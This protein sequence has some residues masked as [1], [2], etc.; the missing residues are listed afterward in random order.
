MTG[1]RE[2]ERR[3]S[4]LLG[5]GLALVVHGLALLALGWTVAP[6][7]WDPPSPP[8]PVVELRLLHQRP[9]AQSVRQPPPA[10][11]KAA[12][13]A[14]ASVGSPTPSA[15]AIPAPAPAAPPHAAGASARGSPV[16]QGG[17]GDLSGLLRAALGCANRDFSHLTDAE[18]TRCDRGFAT[19]ARTATKVDAIPP[20]KRAYYD[21]VVKAYEKMH[22]PAPLSTPH[23][24][25]N[26]GLD[27]RWAGPPGAHAPGFGCKIAIGPIP[28][29]A[30]SYH[31]KPPHSLKLGRLPCFITPPSGFATEEADVQA[32]ASLR[33]RT[34][35]AA[36]AA[37]FDVP[38]P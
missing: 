21:A 7:F 35:D 12:H 13:P 25:D 8:Q 3:R 17:E 23:F 31:D 24:G 32:P 37:Q 6:R 22:A 11:A 30:K 38:K 16:G 19:A 1:G 26:F 14:P 36:H 10:T 29:G 2:A 9:R 27:E 4:A 18:R 15:V 20:E 5:G 34:D 28:R 33:E